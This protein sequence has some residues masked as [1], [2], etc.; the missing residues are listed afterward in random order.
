MMMMMYLLL[1][2][3]LLLLYVAV[4]AYFLP[5]QFACS[6]EVEVTSVTAVFDDGQQ[7]QRRQQQQ[8]QQQGPISNVITNI[9]SISCAATDDY[10]Q[11]SDV[12]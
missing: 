5:I 1:L 12:D 2:L 6:M 9:T 8:Q 10:D 11:Q 7:P 4:A 3:L